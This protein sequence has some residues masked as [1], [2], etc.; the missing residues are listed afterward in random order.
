M[1]KLIFNTF[2]IKLLTAI[3]G[4]LTAIVVSR[5]LGTSGKGEQSLILATISIVLIFSNI[6]GGAT[7][8]YFSIRIPKFHLILL[9][10]LWSLFISFVSFFFS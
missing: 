2:S 6:I 10:Y 1:K 7:L 3:S 4:F 5:Y 8:V 9:S